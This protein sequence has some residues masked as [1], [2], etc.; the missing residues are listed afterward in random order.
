MKKC[1][2][3]FEGDGFVHATR[4]RWMKRSEEELEIQKTKVGGVGI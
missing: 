2:L 3:I 1:K 4:V